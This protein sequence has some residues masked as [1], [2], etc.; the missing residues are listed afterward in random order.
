MY[1]ALLLFQSRWLKHARQ[2]HWGVLYVL[3]VRPMCCNSLSLSSEPILVCNKRADFSPFASTRFAF[4]LFV[5]ATIGSAKLRC[6][7]CDLGKKRG[8]STTR[9][10]RREREW[11]NS[12]CFS[13]VSQSGFHCCYCCCRRRCRRCCCCYF[14]FWPHSEFP[15]ASISSANILLALRRPNQ[16]KQ[17]YLRQ[18]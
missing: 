15:A 6:R 4:P 10:G 17:Y 2:A 3:Y 13:R 12:T 18:Y 8:R 14:R 1:D 5:L 16:N 11:R 9:R 7:H